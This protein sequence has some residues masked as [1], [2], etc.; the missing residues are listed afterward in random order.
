MSAFVNLL[1]ILTE[2]LLTLKIQLA[3]IL[4][5]EISQ[6]SHM[7]TTV[8]LEGRLKGNSSLEVAISRC[9]LERLLSGVETV[10]VGL[11]MLGVMEV[12]NL[13]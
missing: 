7:T 4:A 10:D 11:V 2:W 5:N 12:H 9:L 6:N 13:S 3:F 1:L 8:E